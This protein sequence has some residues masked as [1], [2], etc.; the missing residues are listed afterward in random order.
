M[1]R[2]LKPTALLVLCFEVL[3]VLMIVAPWLLTRVDPLATD[4]AQVLAAPSL[5]HPFGTDQTGRDL[6]ARIIHGARSSVL[7]GVVAAFGAALI[8]TVLGTIAAFGS[9][10]ERSLFMRITE[11]GMTLPEF[12]IALLIVA[13]TNTGLWGVTLAV[14]L[15][16]IPGYAR[17]ATVSA[18]NAVLTEAYITAKVLGV[19]RC[20]RFFVYALPTAVRP[21]FALA[22]V[23]V[24]VAILMIS[25]L[26]FLGLGLTPPDP[27]WGAMLSQSKTYVNRA[28]WPLLFPGVSLIA[29]VAYFMLRGKQL[30][31]KWL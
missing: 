12:L 24:G 1:R 23:G 19:G 25:G 21:V 16:T 30:Q 17:I 28:W 18:R 8:G 14:T 20:R 3:L 22:L 15:A 10:W 7:T 31:R 4:A 29:V 26:T 11:A 6:L 5:A 27:D 9:G 13:Y 2:F